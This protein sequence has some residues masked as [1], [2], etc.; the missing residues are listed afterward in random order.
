MFDSVDVPNTDE[1][2]IEPV[3]VPT[4]ALKYVVVV[5]N[6]PEGA[7]LA[8]FA[9]RVRPATVDAAELIIVARYV[10]PPTRVTDVGE[11]VPFHVRDVTPA[12]P[13]AVAAD[14][15]KGTA[16]PA[17]AVDGHR[18]IVTFPAVATKI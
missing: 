1:L 11:P 13:V 12:E 18:A 16:V 15:T 10:V 8:T 5:E 4:V 9:G 7:A 3:S 2:V 6:T 17:G 14:H